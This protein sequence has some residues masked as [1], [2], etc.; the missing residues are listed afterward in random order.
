MRRA[1]HEALQIL[2]F[3]IPMC[4][5]VCVCQGG[6]EGGTQE[7]REEEK[8][9]EGGGAHTTHV[10]LLARTYLIIKMLSKTT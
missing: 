1:S 7:E 10:R 6:R 9:S 2:A 4:A 5:G 8:E 3:L